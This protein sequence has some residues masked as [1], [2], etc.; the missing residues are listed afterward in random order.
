MK[1]IVITTDN[2][3]RIEDFG[4]PQHE[5]IGKAV[6]GWIEIVRPRLLQRPYC[7]VVNEEGLLHNLPLNL[8]G[9]YLYDTPR[10]G[11]PIVGNVVILKEG[12]VDGEPD[13]VGLSDDEALAFGNKIIEQTRGNIRW[14][15][16]ERSS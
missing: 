13:F 3:M 15:K 14:D 4:A 1:G 11:S 8:Y 2:L 7:M 16:T 6:G 10:H 9:S 12:I 5:T